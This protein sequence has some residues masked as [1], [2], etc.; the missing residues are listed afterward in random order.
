MSIV[1]DKKYTDNQLAVMFDNMELFA[2]GYSWGG[3]ESLM[4][5]G[6]LQKERVSDLDQLQNTI[7]RLHIGLED[8]FDLIGDLESGLNRLKQ[9]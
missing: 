4:T 3:F 2:M 5:P 7:I 1:L 9:I 8:V 6:K